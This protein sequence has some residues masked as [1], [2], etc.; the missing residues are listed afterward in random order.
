MSRLFLCFF[1]LAISISS[2]GQLS[3]LANQYYSEGEYEKAA[4]LYEQLYNEN[5]TADFYFQRYTDCLIAVQKYDDARKIIE[6]E[7]KKRPEEIQLY[8]SLGN[9]Y[10][11]MSQQE[12]AKFTYQQALDKLDANPSKV[13][14]L[15][16]AFTTLALYEEA[17]KVYEKA[18]SL[19]IQN[20]GYANTLADLYRRTGN[21]KMM[22]KYYLET[23]ENSSN[24]LNFLIQTFERN[25]GESDI[26][27]LQKQL[28]EK[29]QKKPD[30]LAYIELLEWSYINQ[31]A[32][33]KALRQAKAYDLQTDGNG[34]RVFN[35]GIIAYNDEDYDTAI[36]SF[37]YILK[38]KSIN[39]SNYLNSQSYILNARRKKI[40]SGIN[41]TKSDLISLQQEYTGFLEK[42]GRNT[43]TATL[44]REYA[45]FEALY[46]NNLPLAIQILE[47]VIGFGG[48]RPEEV[49]QAKLDL[50]DYL[51]MSGDI[52]ESSL[53]FSQV[54]K[55]FKEGVLGEQARYRNAKLS[56]YSGDF[57]WAQAQFD[58]LKSATTRLISNDAIYK[59]V[60]IMDKLNLDTTDVPL[61]L[62][63][64]A[65]LLFFQ[66]RIDDGMAKLDS[67]ESAF[68]E[69]SLS[70]DILFLK[71][72][73][74]KKLRQPQVSLK[75]YN[76]LV[77]KYPEDILVDD[78]L[79]NMAKIYDIQLEDKEKAMELYMKLFVD[80]TGST[81]AV[82]ARKRFRILRGDEL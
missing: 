74:Y 18:I 45:E 40:T 55:S 51:L 79:Y 11:R 29:I 43:R 3:K 1:L 35:I 64:Q 54:D 21:T 50:G 16:R 41:Y 14:R 73:I 48:L 20:P 78:A 38:S 77:E 62:F 67:I 31:K 72:D 12:K 26:I 17:I 76:E 46:M 68:P 47:S 57:E 19:K 10:D 53:L 65:E 60:F 69:H 13:D 66:N 59:T 2:Y 27:E 7:I 81:Y 52:W 4:V 34:D 82:D 39:S 36:E 71:A 6:A 37:S 8:V 49:A 22:I 15:A 23:A 9:L 28:F 30:E 63:A 70:A 5:K 42:Y 44:M 25:L 61:L 32:Y 80:Y 58:I 24:N 33:D 75:L 56:Y